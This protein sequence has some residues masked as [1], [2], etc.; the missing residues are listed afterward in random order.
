MNKEMKRLNYWI[1]K[2]IPLVYDDT[3]SL[4]ELVAKT[5]AYLNKVIESQNELSNEVAGFIDRFESD[6]TNTVN[7]I[8]VEWQVSGKLEGIINEALFNQKLDKE[9]FEYFKADNVIE[10][11][12]IRADIL[13]SDNE[14]AIELSK[15]DKKKLDKKTPTFTFI[16]DSGFDDHTKSIA[17]VFKGRK[18]QCGFAIALQ[19]MVAVRENPERST[20]INPYLELKNKYG[21]SLLPLSLRHGVLTS[22]N[23]YER[24][25]N[26]I[27]GAKNAWQD[28]GVEIA[29]WVSPSSRIHADYD[30]M[31]D[32]YSYAFNVYEG[33]V[34]R[35]KIQYFTPNDNTQKL[36]RI[37]LNNSLDDLKFV[38][39]ET[40]KNNG[41]LC[42]Y[43][44]TTLTS[45]SKDF[46]LSTIS[47]VIDYIGMRGDIKS[48]DQAVA[49]YFGSKGYVTSKQKPSNNLIDLSKASTSSSNG[50]DYLYIEP[51]FSVVGNQ[52]KLNV[53]GSVVIGK[54]YRIIYN[55]PKDYL[56]KSDFTSQVFVSVKAYDNV[57]TDTRANINITTIFP[58]NSR[59]VVTQPLWREPNTYESISYPPN[60]STWGSPTPVKVQIDITFTGGRVGAEFTLKDIL[61]GITGN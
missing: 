24:T 37:H 20:F 6:L 48:P 23:Q 26:E 8:L 30:S 38:I 22:P 52:L 42:F 41:F 54:P 61:I 13:K 25:Y 47:Q 15:L 10:L 11:N 16:F 17:D 31:L 33:N 57:V 19:E 45:P 4:Y 9:V 60:D 35:S 7:D 27:I 50:F 29:G 2:A 5:V 12:K 28:L 34:D 51:E 14:Q 3:L 53:V 40:I 56:T 55:L 36:S 49:Q 46:E 59:D 32:I 21:F 58:D 1:Q 18:L 39:D 43:G 44:H